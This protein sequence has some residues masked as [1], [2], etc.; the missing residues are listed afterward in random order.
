MQ[1]SKVSAFLWSVLIDFAISLEQIRI[2]CEMNNN[3]FLGLKWYFIVIFV[4]FLS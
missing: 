4:L 1:L 3:K 2:D